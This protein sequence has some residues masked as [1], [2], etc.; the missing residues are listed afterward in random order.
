M[1]DRNDSLSFLRAIYLF[2]LFLFYYYYRAAY[3]TVSAKGEIQQYAK[4]RSSTRYGAAGDET[5][6]DETSDAPNTVIARPARLPA[7]P[8]LPRPARLARTP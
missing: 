6:D 4:F 8:P 5:S 2:L 1:V 7:R 3:S